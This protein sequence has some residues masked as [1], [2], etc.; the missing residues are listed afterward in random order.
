MNRTL[1]FLGGVGVGAGLEYI[2]DP[3]RGRRRRKLAADQL[4][5]AAHHAADAAEVTQRDIENRRRGAAARLKSRFRSDEPD[6]AVLVE[7]V[8]SKMGRVV[9]HPGA[10]HVTAKHGTV[11][12]S[13]PILRDEMAGFLAAVRKVRGVKEVDNQLTAHHQPGDVPGLQGT[14]HRPGTRPDVFQEHWSPATRALVGAGSLGLV[15]VGAARGGLLGTALGVAGLGMLARA[16]TNLEM[17]RLL[18]IGAGRRAVDFRKAIHVHAPVDEVYRFWSNFENF[19]LFMDHVREVRTLGNGR[20]HWTVAGPLGAEVRFDAEV[21]RAVENKVLAWKTVG[22]PGV[23][24]AGIVQFEEDPTVGTRLDIRMSYNP[25]LGAA[26]HTIASLFRTDPKHAMDE[27]LVRFK[28][29]IEDGKTTAH[30]VEVTRQRL[31]SAVAP[32]D[33]GAVSTEDVMTLPEESLDI[34]NGGMGAPTA[35]E[36]F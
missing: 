8:R 23:R 32:E 26:G 14:S 15:G 4:V 33:G 24:H 21:T 6:E 29:L 19:P 7:R 28:S 10:I 5:S 31:E 27:D 3:A 12:L 16:A 11:T 34:R 18:G 13:G 2:F 22:R 17:K 9:S 30:G 36:Q 1:T 35:E 20:T 25:V